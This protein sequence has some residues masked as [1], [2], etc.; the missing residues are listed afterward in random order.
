MLAY[1]NIDLVQLIIDLFFLR[2]LRN[3]LMDYLTND[4]VIRSEN[5]MTNLS[6]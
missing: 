4:N 1:L 2:Q 3:L 5:I 6:Y